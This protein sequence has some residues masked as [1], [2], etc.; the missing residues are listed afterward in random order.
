MENFPHIWGQIY[1]P[2][3]MKDRCKDVH[4]L[5]LLASPGLKLTLLIDFYSQLHF[6]KCINM[7]FT[8]TNSCPSADFSISLGFKRWSVWMWN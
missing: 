5:I 2:D 3:H 8:A 7:W 6:E 4:D 1:D